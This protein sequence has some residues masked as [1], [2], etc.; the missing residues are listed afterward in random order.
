VVPIASKQ[1]RIKQ[2]DAVLK[3]TYSEP[4]EPQAN[5][6]AELSASYVYLAFGG[7]GADAASSRQLR[8]YTTDAGVFTCVGDDV[9]ICCPFPLDRESQKVRVIAG[10]LLLAGPPQEYRLHLNDICRIAD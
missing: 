10:G 1:E 7:I 4:S 6:S 8:K 9:S 2:Q 5:D 3:G